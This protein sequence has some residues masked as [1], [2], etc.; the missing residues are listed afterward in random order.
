M[1][2]ST[3]QVPNHF[4]GLPGRKPTGLALACAVVIALVIVG[5]SMFWLAQGRSKAPAARRQTP[6]T[7][8][9]SIPT[10]G[11]TAVTPSLLAMFYDTFAGNFHGWPVGSNGGYFRILVNNSLILS[12]TNP[13]TPLVESVPTIT[14]LD[15]YV[16]TA[17]F[18]LNQGDKNDGMGLYLRGDSTLYHDYRVDINGNNTIDLV[19]EYLDEKEGEQEIPLVRPI[20]TGYLN[21]P[22][23]PN[24]LTVFLIGPSIT[25]EVNNIVVVTANDPAYTNGQVALFARHGSTS[26]GVTVSFT[27]I[28]IDR[29]ASPFMTPVPT[30]TLTP[31]ASTGANQG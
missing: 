8:T 13:N 11:A 21:P 28:E 16:I 29:L 7:A 10:W 19:K 22:G 14:N 12:D 4:P 23:R 5:G 25:V 26:S 3:E 27:R 20:H 30:P 18:T 1:S 17:D 24:T 6:P 15:N 31:R 2:T 9:I